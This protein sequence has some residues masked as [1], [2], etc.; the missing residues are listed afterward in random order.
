MEFDDRET[1]KKAI[2]ELARNGGFTL[3]QAEAIIDVAMM[4]S[5]GIL[6]AIKGLLHKRERGTDT[7]TNSN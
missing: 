4:S 2:A 7:L 3:Q 1:R 5:Q 6:L